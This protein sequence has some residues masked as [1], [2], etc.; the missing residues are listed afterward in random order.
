MLIAGDRRR[1]FV[2]RVVL[3]TG[4]Q[5]EAPKPETHDLGSLAKKRVSVVAENV[6]VARVAVALA[7]AF[8]I[9]VFAAGWGRFG[10]VSRSPSLEWR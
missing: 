3:N 5:V 4:A 7:E 9:N 6:P 10:I 8:G 2:R 1:V